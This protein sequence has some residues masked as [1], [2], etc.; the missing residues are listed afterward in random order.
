MI[1][2]LTVHHK[3]AKW[4]DV[5]MAYL[6]RNLH[7]PY[8]VV[9]N[10]QD[11]PGAPAHKFDQVIPAMG[12]HG[13]KLNYMASE[14]VATVHPDDLLM[15]IDGDAF[16][17]NDPMPTVHAGLEHSTLVAVQR[18]ENRGDKQ[19]HP[20]FCVI[21]AGDWDRIRGD[22]SSGFCWETDTGELV[23]DHGANLS[24]NLKRLGETWTPLLRTNRTDIHP[25]CFAV[26][27]GIVYHHGA[28]FRPALMRTMGSKA[29]TRWVRGEQIPVVGTVI[30]LGWVALFNFWRDRELAENRK[31]S[32]RIFRELER[33]PDFYRQ[34][35]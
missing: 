22:W 26:Y 2:V 35:L 19:P 11:V 5:Q 33:D 27:G 28:G 9:A 17:I 6:R 32:D 13:G 34:F 30:R 24:A 29:P 10:L 15:F 14:T 3:S 12:S 1:H 8:R 18:A 21:R 25:I 23:T 7:E 31:M 16:P 4:I 20:C